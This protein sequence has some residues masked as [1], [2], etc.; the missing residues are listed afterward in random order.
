MD[1]SVCKS[2]PSV[3]LVKAGFPQRSFSGRYGMTVIKRSLLYLRLSRELTTSLSSAKNVSW[4]L[5]GLLISVLWMMTSVGLV[6]R[7]MLQVV[8]RLRLLP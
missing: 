1:Q 3:D 2:K 4:S 6:Y 8:D 5:I 7:S